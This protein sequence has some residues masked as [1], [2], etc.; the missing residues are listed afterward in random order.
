[1]M[2]L[3]LGVI[4][5]TTGYQNEIELQRYEY[6]LASALVN[7]HTTAVGRGIGRS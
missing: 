5:R 6:S 3:E 1:M 4:E 2:P 7:L